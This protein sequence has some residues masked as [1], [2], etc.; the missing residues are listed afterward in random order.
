[1]QHYT[2]DRS[3]TPPLLRKA[4]AAGA[5]P[6]VLKLASTSVS[7]A[8][9]FAP[10]QLDK[11]ASAARDDSVDGLLGRTR[12]PDW[13]TLQSISAACNITMPT[14][15]ESIVNGIFRLCVT[16]GWI[17]NGLGNINVGQLRGCK[18]AA[19]K[20]TLKLCPQWQRGATMVEQGAS[21]REIVMNATVVS[22]LVN[23]AASGVSSS[24]SDGRGSDES[25][26]EGDDDGAGGGFVDDSNVDQA[27]D[28]LATEGLDAWKAEMGP[29][30]PA[31][32]PSYW[33]DRE[34]YTPQELDEGAGDVCDGR[35]DDLSDDGGA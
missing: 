4:H 31:L 22:D 1:M 9:S 6:D 24:E 7:S 30:G 2:H 29:V 28:T 8:A 20:A 23:G 10:P 5:F 14:P 32:K 33:D 27:K 3:K 25:M 35:L 15:V 17:E 12:A 18:L 19:V 13:G 26:D 11:G 21:M 16:R 34:H